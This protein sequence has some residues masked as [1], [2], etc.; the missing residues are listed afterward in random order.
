M[1]GFIVIL[2]MT[3]LGHPW[4]INEMKVQI[5]LKRRL[6]CRGR[7]LQLCYLATLHFYCMDSLANAYP[8]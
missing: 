3:P 5:I 6:Y 4:I 7:S 2:F 8:W 1:F